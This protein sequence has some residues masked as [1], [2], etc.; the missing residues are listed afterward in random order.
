M[1]LGD[2]FDDFLLS[3]HVHPLLS[4]NLLRSMA[5]ETGQMRRGFETRNPIERGSLGGAEE[6]SQK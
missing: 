6:A 2:V 3:C 4:Q 1:M 5:L